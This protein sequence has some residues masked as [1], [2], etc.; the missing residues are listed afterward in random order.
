MNNYHSI[1]N[2]MQLDLVALTPGFKL[3]L[4]SPLALC[5]GFVFPLLNVGS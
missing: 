1:V 3:G 4:G 5:P 2:A